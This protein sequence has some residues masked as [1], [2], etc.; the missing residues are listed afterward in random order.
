MARLL[1]ETNTNATVMT[2]RHRC[3]D[4]EL[5]PNPSS[6][7][8]V[9]PS[10]PYNKYVHII[11]ASSLYGEDR[12][13]TIKFLRVLLDN[14]IV[15]ASELAEC[16]TQERTLLWGDVP[17]RVEIAGFKRRVANSA[18]PPEE[19]DA[20]VTVGRLIREGALAAFTSVELE[21]ESLR[22]SAAVMEFN[23][24]EGCSISN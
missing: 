5:L 2:P 15:S 17:I 24:L 12:I 19:I 9:Q 6:S 14:G 22:R 23:A 11:E 21:I 1:G 4:G 3:N 20:L 7:A 10:Y 18:A 16:A 13:M 8:T